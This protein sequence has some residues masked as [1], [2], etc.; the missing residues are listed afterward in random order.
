MVYYIIILFKNIIKFL[1]WFYPHFLIYL[2]TLLHYRTNSIQ[3]LKFKDLIVNNFSFHL[4]N[5]IQSIHQWSK[6]QYKDILFSFENFHR[7]STLILADIEKLGTKKFI[8]VCF[9][10][11]N[12]SPSSF[13][14]SILKSFI[15]LNN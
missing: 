6:R 2:I 4:R 11:Q 8:K 15:N 5:I 1:R 3:R 13:E 9:L 14:T 12:L 7:C 10:N